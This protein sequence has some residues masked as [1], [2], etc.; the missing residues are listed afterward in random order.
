MS[1]DQDA[2]ALCAAALTHLRLEEAATMHPD[3]TIARVC[4]RML[5]LSCAEPASLQLSNVPCAEASSC[6]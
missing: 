2:S 4:S 3:P 6:N 1:S 5:K